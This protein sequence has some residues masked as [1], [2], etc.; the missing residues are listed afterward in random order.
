M[1]VCINYA[2]LLNW[3]H[4]LS[5]MSN[6]QYS[7]LS[8]GLSLCMLVSSPLQLYLMQ[9]FP[10]GTGKFI[11]LNMFFWGITL[12]LHAACFS[13][14][15]MLIARCWIGFFTASI[16]PGFSKYMNTKSP[17]FHLLS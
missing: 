10:W 13:Y 2:R 8:S 14:A 9:K 17:I 12:A 6:N 7:W 16:S 4:D 1:Q 3:Q 5:N 11:A 15:D